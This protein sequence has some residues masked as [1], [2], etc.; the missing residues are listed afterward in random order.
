MPSVCSLSSRANMNIFRCTA[1]TAWV[2]GTFLLGAC[3]GGD[4]ATPVWGPSANAQAAS[5]AGGAGNPDGDAGLGEVAGLG[6]A[7]SPDEPAETPAIPS[8]GRA[9]FRDGFETGAITVDKARADAWTSMGLEMPGRSTATVVSDPMGSPQRVGRFMVPDDGE[10]FR[11]EIQRRQFPWGRYRY[12]VSH[13]IPSTWPAF[14]YGTIITQWHGFG[15]PDADGKTVNLNPPIALAVYGLQPKW[16]LHMYRLVEPGKPVTKL[17]RIPIDVPIAYD[18]WNDWVFDITWSRLLPDGT[19]SPGLVVVTLN[20]KEVARVKGDNNYHQQWSPYL[21]MGI[22][23]S[24]WRA[25][26]DRGASGGPPV[27]VHHKDLRVT[28]MTGCP[29]AD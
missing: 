22:Y 7:G 17:D 26:P 16:E 13:H 27:V 21:Q 14:K 20:G 12:A 10:S 8:C 25:G 2:L 5:S 23:R 9:V 3:G 6:N 28:D 19:V 1:A 4:S 18:R 11:A 29:A 24:S 15:M